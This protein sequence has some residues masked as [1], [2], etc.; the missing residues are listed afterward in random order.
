V[1]G[2]KARNWF[3]WE[4]DMKYS[5]LF[6]GSLLMFATNAHATPPH[7]VGSIGVFNAGTWYLDTD[8]SFGWSGTGSGA[9]EIHYFGQAGDKPVVLYGTPCFSNQTAGIAVTRDN[10]WYASYNNLDYEWADDPNA[11]V[12]GSAP[13]VPLS[14]GGAAVTFSGGNF[15]VDWNSNHVQDSGD[16]NISFGSGWQIPVMGAWSTSSGGVR[17]GTYDVGTHSWYVDANGSNSWNAGDAIYNFGFGNADYP[18]S[19][20]YS[21]G[22]DHI[23]IFITGDWYMDTNGNHQWDGVAGGD[24]HWQ[25]GNPGDTPVVSRQTWNGQCPIDDGTSLHPVDG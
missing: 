24:S 19:I 5:L 8:R 16:A 15:L 20:P 12:F 14:W 13:F 22:V 10:N 21:D 23:G 11:F 1:L 18:V 4:E 7:P 9:D 2:G 6:T 25:F 17:I 3:Y